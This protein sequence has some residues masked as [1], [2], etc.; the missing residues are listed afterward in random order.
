MATQEKG[1]HTSTPIIACLLGIPLL[2]V[3]TPMALA[4][5]AATSDLTLNG[6]AK[7]LTQPKGGSVLWLTPAKE[8]QAGTAFSTR[9]IEF[10]PRYVFSTSF[11]FKMT[12]PGA[13]G[14]SDG[15]AFVLQTEGASA[16]GANGGGLGYVGI[17]PSVAVEF[18]TWQNAG[19]DINDNHVAILTNGQLI[20]HDSQ[21]PYG[22]TNCQP[23]G[24]FGC[25]SNGDTWSVWIDYDGKA[26]NVAV[27]DNS[28]I[29]PANLISRPID[30]PGLLGQPSA[31]VGFTA[32]TGL[33]WENH[34][35]VNW[36]FI[37]APADS[38]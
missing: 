38:K 21:T 12:D 6:S 5:P 34:Y 22:V 1:M 28:L 30:I 2:G 18:D 13:G 24:A 11:Q 26:L 20:D 25:M 16:L 32:G 19:I 35:I 9:A 10:N 31:F 23:T 3:T 27:A 17:A 29:R 4:N 33:G 7:I 14:A 15:M 36:Q 8:D 37:A